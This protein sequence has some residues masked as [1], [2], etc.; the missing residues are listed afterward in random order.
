M[1]SSDSPKTPAQGFVRHL[2]VFVLW[3]LALAL[4]G[5][6]L[7]PGEKAIAIR[8]QRISSFEIDNPARKR[9]GPLE[10]RG[11]LVLTSSD[12]AFGG[13]SGLIVQEDGD[14]FI[15]CSD[16]GFWLRGRIIYRLGLA[17]RVVDAALSPIV[18]PDGRSASRLDTESMTGDGGALYVGLEGAPPRILRFDRDGRGLPAGG[19]SIPVPPEL[20]DLPNNRGLEA[21]AFVPDECR[22]GGTLIAISERG[23]TA[24]GDIKAYL[25]GGPSPGPFAIKRRDEFDIT[26][27]AVLPGGDLLIL[28]RLFSRDFRLGMRIRR[29]PLGGLRPGALIDGAVLI[30]ADRGFEIDN[31]EALAVHRTRSGEIRITILSDDNFLPIQRTLLLQFAL[32]DE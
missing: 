5:S 26:D 31:M 28:E 30:E 4:P 22:L 15:A 19:R 3:P 23:L 1:A 11:G 7:S 8:A 27:A 14:R 10:F 12:Q 16:R 17:S 18:D 13:L 24:A 9:F 20:K 25:I 32:L 21:L 29:L 6:D 2:L